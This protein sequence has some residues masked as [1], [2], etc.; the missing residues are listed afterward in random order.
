LQ[1][2]I[3]WYLGLKAHIGV[4]SKTKQVHSAEVTAANVHDSQVLEDLL[5]GEERRVWR[6]SAY[7]GQ[8]EVLAEHAPLTSDFT[9]AKGRRNRPLTE[10]DKR[11]NRTKSGVHA[12]VEHVFCA[13]KRQF[14]F[15]TPPAK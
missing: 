14:G 8:Q 4:D 1:C 7:T 11:R 2:E 15:T 10:E 12:K 5:H 6:D 3:Q 13:L 9:H